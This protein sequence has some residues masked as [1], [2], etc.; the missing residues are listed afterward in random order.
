MTQN[1]AEFKDLPDEILENILY[2]LPHGGKQETEERH[3]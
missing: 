2:Q 3:T 1:P